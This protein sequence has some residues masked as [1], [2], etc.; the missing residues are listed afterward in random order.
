MT[1]RRAIEAAK[2]KRENNEL[3]RKVE[4]NFALIGQA[5]V[6]EQLNAKIGKLA[7]TNSRVMITGPAGAGKEAAARQIH[8]QSPRMNQNFIAIHGA[9]IGSDVEQAKRIVF[10]REVDGDVE[11]GLIEQAHGGTLFLD[12]ISSFPL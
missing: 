4:V 12:D 6:I 10:G 11:T 9:I 8:N 7:Q 1:V 5:G 3:R 2:L